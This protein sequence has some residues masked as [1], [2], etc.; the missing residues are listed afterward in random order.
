[1]M[2]NMTTTGKLVAGFALFLLYQGLVLALRVN[3]F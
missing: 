3:L 2:T 1:M